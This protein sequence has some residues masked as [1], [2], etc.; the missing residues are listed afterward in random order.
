M[1]PTKGVL[2]VVLDPIIGG[3]VTIKDLAGK[4]LTT[5]D[6]DNETGQAEFL[7]PRKKAY[8]VEVNSPGYAPVT[9]K[10]KVLAASAV[11]RLKLIPR[12]ATLRLL[13]VPP[14]AQ[15]F[16]D[17]QL[18]EYKDQPI[19]ADLSPGEHTLQIKHPEYNDYDDRVTLKEA[20]AVYDLTIQRFGQSGEAELS[21]A[22]KRYGLDRRS[23]ARPRECR[24]PS[25]N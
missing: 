13:D 6:A 9:A 12:F 11:V 1:Q 10:S 3:K 14:N 15:I 4:V 2:A 21:R 18:R 5:G 19:F 25:K 24:R 23:R 22:A 17:K 16:L 20:G 8:Q 7:M